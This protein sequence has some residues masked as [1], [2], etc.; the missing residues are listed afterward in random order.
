MNREKLLN[1]VDSIATSKSYCF[2]SAEPNY[3]TTQLKEYPSAWLLPPEFHSIEG[4]NHGLETFSLTL[5][6][7][8][9]AA[10]LDFDERNN[11]RVKMED[12]LLDIFTSLTDEDFVAEV[13]SLRIRHSTNSVARHGEVVATATA[14]VITFF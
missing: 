9:D 7:M 11:L 4:R 3:I 1:A 5:H 2:H 14:E 8:H 6:L 10:K 13:E 12:D